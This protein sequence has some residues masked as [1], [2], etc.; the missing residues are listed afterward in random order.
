MHR[1]L[2]VSLTLCLVTLGS[3]AAAAVVD[4]VF[5]G[6]V[7]C[8]PQNGVQ[9]CD[10]DLSHRVE[11]WDGVPLDLN[12]TI[13]PASVD[14]AF[15][16]VIDLHGWGLGKNGGP[17]TTWA[18]EG[19]VVLSF[20]ARGFH[21]SCGSPA[22]RVPDA[23]LSD[24]DV[25]ATRGWTHLGDARYE[26]RDAQYLAGL[27]ADEG[28]VIPDKVA[29]TG[30][31]Y[32]GGRSMVLG[33]LRDR[34]MLPDGSFVPWQSPGG[35][36]MEIAAAVPLIPWSDL[37]YALAP[38][39]ATLDTRAENPYGTR[40][41]V[42]K[43]EWNALLFNAG[44]G[45]GFYAPEGT[46]PAADLI[47][48]HERTMHGEPYDADPASQALITELTSFHSAYY[49]DDSVPPAPTFIYNAWTDDLF[50]GDE[51][52]RFFLKTRARHPEAEIA[53]NL[54]DGFGHPRASLGASNLT[55]I[56][57]R[58]RKFFA[59]HLKGSGDPLPRVETWTQACGGS[60][61]QGPFTADEWN[62][63][64]PGEV[65]FGDVAPRTIDEASGDE[66]VGAAIGPLGGGPCREIDAAD[67]VTAATYRFDAATG[68][69][70]TLMGS[71]TIIARMAVSGVEYAQVNGRLWD[72]APDGTQALVTHAV[73]RPRGDDP[74]PQVFQL[75]PNG[76]E[77]APGHAPKLELVGRSVPSSQ[78]SAGPF[79]VTISDLELRLPVL[80]APDG[81]VVL[82]PSAP[83]L[84]LDAAEPPPWPPAPIADCSEASKSRILLSH[85][86]TDDKDKLVWSWKGGEATIETDRGTSLCLY[87]GNGELL[88]SAPAPSTGTC[89]DD[90]CWSEKGRKARYQ[91]RQTTRTGVRSLV[92]RDGTKTKLALAGK[93][94]RLGLPTTPIDPL[95]LTVQLVD[96]TG[97][98]WG[99]S[100]AA[101]K[102][103]GEEK[104]KAG[105]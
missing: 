73:Y 61:Q 77:F 22:S 56:F 57:D 2:R 6:R 65:R 105:S 41:G 83:V 47:G 53:V 11:T 92:V 18:L 60:T 21:G 95:P 36:D 9:F 33:A 31:S 55:L 58:T 69:G 51:A 85:G 15:P 103:N 49:V 87:D 80:E 39:G 29:A 50:P 34:V 25:C 4:S 7:A 79:S 1:A 67:D 81:A 68:E 14:G 10:S 54:A 8:A 43:E 38:N 17:S 44:M 97:G 96:G 19:Y 93:G 64:H 35:L 62:A 71:P 91:D 59:R 70:Y 63:I 40:S 84:P 24:P 86:K 37:A 104:L 32:G 16:L 42:A 75:H 52:L 26:A 88:V 27:L 99:T 89:G 101:P 72:V 74:G 76:W 20:S 46:D 30:I 3:S 66:A 12:V 90:A 28:H 48:W 82:E 13:P 98:C 94:L 102:K 78:A 23:S 45:T 5:G 100:Y